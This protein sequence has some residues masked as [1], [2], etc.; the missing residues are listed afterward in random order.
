LAWFSFFRRESAAA[1]VPPTPPLLAGRYRIGARLGGGAVGEVYEAVDLRTGAS[2]AVKRIPL[3][4]DIPSAER[5]EWLS[6]LHREADISHRL[7]HPDILAVHEAGL[8]PHEAWLAME[9][10]HGNDLSRYTQPHRLLPETLVLRIGAR[11]GAALAHA[12]ARGITH[13]DLKPA[14]VVIDLGT[15]VLKLIDFGVARVDDATQTRT[16][17]TLGT[18]AYMAPEQLAGAPA[19]PATD[20]YALGVMLFELLCGRRPHQADTLGELLRSTQRDPPARLGKLRPDLPP[21]V[22]SAI[23]QLLAREPEQRPT[24]LADWAADLAG[25]AAVVARVVAP[26]VALRL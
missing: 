19:G 12:H 15:G 21:A 23:E 1:S 9:R 6:R 16:G 11:V 24:D 7:D 8:T 14:N 22:V 3:A 20:T 10:V 25:L 4:A 17:M 2:V 18:P 5:A 26:D 13:R